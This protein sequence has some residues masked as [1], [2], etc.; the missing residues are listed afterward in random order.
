MNFADIIIRAFGRG[1][2]FTAGKDF[3]RF[4]EGLFR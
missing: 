1:L 3:M 2:G 4:L